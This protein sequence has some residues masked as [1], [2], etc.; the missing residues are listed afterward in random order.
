MSWTLPEP[1]W[2]GYRAQLAVHAD[3]RVLLHYRQGTDMTAS[4]PESRAAAL[5]RLP[6][7]TGL[8][9]GM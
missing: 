7:D 6:P 4:F 8:D 2:D 3:E 5:A 1:T 9:G